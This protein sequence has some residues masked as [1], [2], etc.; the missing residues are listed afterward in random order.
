VKIDGNAFTV[1]REG[2]ID[3]ASIRRAAEE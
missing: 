3:A 1:L 2:R